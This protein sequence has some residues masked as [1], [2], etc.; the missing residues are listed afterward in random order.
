MDHTPDF[1][2]MWQATKEREAHKNLLFSSP[3]MSASIKNPPR[4][5]NSSANSTHSLD[6]KIYVLFCC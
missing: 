4:L 1:L 3:R 2:T 6:I 5:G